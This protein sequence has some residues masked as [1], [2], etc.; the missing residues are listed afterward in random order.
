[1]NYTQFPLRLLDSGVEQ[2]KFIYSNFTKTQPNKA[3][4]TISSRS[5]SRNGWTF[6]SGCSFKL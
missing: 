6:L 2:Y 4:A 3:S 5:N 1:M